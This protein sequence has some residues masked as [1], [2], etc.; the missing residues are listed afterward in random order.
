MNDL[1]DVIDEI[2]NKTSNEYNKCIKMMI[3]CM[4]VVRGTLPDIAIEGL[5]SAQKYWF[6]DQLSVE[7]LTQK[8]IQ[9]WTY[10]DDINSSTKFSDKNT[11]AIRSVICLLYVKNELESNDELLEFFFDMLKYLEEDTSKLLDS[12]IGVVM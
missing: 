2:I 12:L 11:C 3:N 9:L 7:E 8:R 6:E 10:L 4:Q 1:N 5:E